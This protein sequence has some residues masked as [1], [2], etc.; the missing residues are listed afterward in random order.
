MTV[1]DLIQHLQRF[2]SGYEV[3]VISC[4]T[5]IGAEEGMNTWRSQPSNFMLP[6]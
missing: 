4:A 1:R 6:N 3:F 2:P 5:E